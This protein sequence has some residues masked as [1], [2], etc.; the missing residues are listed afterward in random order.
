MIFPGRLRTELY[1]ELG[2]AV[3]FHDAVLDEAIEVALECEKSGVGVII[4]RGG[5][6]EVI[7]KVVKIPVVNCE[8]THSDLINTLLDIKQE[9][10][11]DLKVVALIC[12]AN[13]AY[14]VEQLQR[15][16]GIEVKQFW[17]WSDGNE[18][19]EKVRQAKAAGIK[20]VVGASLTT[21]VARE[22]G[23]K[24]YLMQVG[25]ET[26]KQ[27]VEK[28]R[29]ILDIRRNDLAYSEKVKSIL[30]FAYEGILFVDNQGII[31]Y[32]NPRTEDILKGKYPVL[33]G[34][35]VKD[36]IPGWDDDLK[37]L[38]LGQ[39]TKVGDKHIAYN[40]VPVFVHDK[41][42]GMVITFT[43]TSDLVKAEEK[44][45]NVLHARGLV[46]KYRLKDIVGESLI[47]KET[48]RKAELFGQTDSTVLIIGETGTGK[49]LF[50]H[51]LHRI[52]ERRNKPFVAIN[53]GTLPENLLESELFG[54]EEGA[55]TG[56]K[57]G[58][59]I[60][61]F[62][63]A[64]RGTLFLDEIGEMPFSLQSR[65]LRAIQEKEVMRLG[66]DR[67]IPVDVRIIAATNRNLKEA[68][69]HKEFRSD[70]YYRLNIL[71]LNIPPLRERLE[72]VPLL[73]EYFL[74][75]FRRL[76]NRN[77]PPLSPELM[78]F[79]LSYQWPGNVRE[80]ENLIQKY[81]LLAD[82][83][84]NKALMKEILPKQPN[85]LEATQPANIGAIHSAENELTVKLGSINEILDEIYAKV[86]KIAGGNK[87]RTA[88]ILGVNRM[89]VARWLEQKN[90]GVN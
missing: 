38:H 72:D 46:A 2:P 67:I 70:L 6:A 51:G 34:Q 26:V 79:L 19:R 1:Q 58:G 65:L 27:A 48:I 8:V 16:L 57:K 40:R 83:I 88:E 37:H 9:I 53:C 23:I 30:Q 60:G 15:L 44:I 77:I 50:A 45:R 81:A 5:T 35:Q 17:Y 33:I 90:S 84:D 61:L 71:Q 7:R 52:S 74:N 32:A 11:P 14:D 12:Y 42:E 39:I 36:V 21:R 54:Y 85:K 75:L 28:A 86:Y 87:T 13:V 24:G 66:G 82:S 69:E 78:D 4:S 59:R 80:L 20:V 29:E 22:L 62:E 64:H 63:L 56:A 68:V 49:E 18:L 3:I 76:D 31:D 25:L 41:Y 55:F 73:V 43:E 47:I 89:T 10:G